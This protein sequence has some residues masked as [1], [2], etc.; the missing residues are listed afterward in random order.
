M[1]VA[2]M[3][4]P[5]RVAPGL[6]QLSQMI[7][8][9]G[10]M[11]RPQRRNRSH[12]VPGK[13]VMSCGSGQHISRPFRCLRRARCSRSGGVLLDPS[14]PSFSSRRRRA[15]VCR[16]IECAATSSRLNARCFT[17]ETRTRSTRVCRASAGQP[18]SGGRRFLAAGAAAREI[19]KNDGLQQGN[20][21]RRCFWA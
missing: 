5:S 12:V 21:G 8:A 15:T 3:M 2:L 18:Q 7:R 16:T 19:E 14:R 6:I 13:V 11:R 20:T 17:Q 4:V 9:W 10:S 1:F